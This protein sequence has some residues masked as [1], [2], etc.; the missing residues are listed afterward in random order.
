MRRALSCLVCCFA[1]PFDEE[2]EVFSRRLDD[3]TSKCLKNTQSLAKPQSVLG[4]LRCVPDCAMFAGLGGFGV[5]TCA[6]GGVHA[7]HWA[8]EVDTR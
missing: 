2:W 5:V 4:R 8:L 3:A 1:W 6:W 7:W